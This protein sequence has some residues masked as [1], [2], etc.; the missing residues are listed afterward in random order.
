MIRDTTRKIFLGLTFVFTLVLNGCGGGGGDTLT[1]PPP[2]QQWPQP[3][4]F[5]DFTGGQSR[6]TIGTQGYAGTDCRTCMYVYGVARSSAELGK[7]LPELKTYVQWPPTYNDKLYAELPIDY[8]Q[9]IAVVLKDENS[10]YGD[11]YTIQKV[12]E[13]ADSLTITV[14]KCVA[15][16]DVYGL[17]SRDYFGL[18]LPK[19]TKPIQV[20]TV[21][22]GKPTLPEYLPNGLGAC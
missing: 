3:V 15:F 14:L 13:S 7:L 1:P 11:Q 4:A 20:L 6:F 21:Q 10:K 16:L 18:L 8:N 2:V 17:V 12:E 22:S 5:T 9:K 19:T